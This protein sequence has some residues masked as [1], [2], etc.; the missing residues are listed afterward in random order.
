MN[1]WQESTAWGYKEMLSEPWGLQMQ[2]SMQKKAGQLVLGGPYLRNVYSPVF[3]L[4]CELLG[5]MLRIGSAQGSVLRP[6]LMNSTASKGSSTI[7]PL[8][9]LL[10]VYLPHFSYWCGF[11]RSSRASPTLVLLKEIGH[12]IWVKKRCS[13]MAYF[14]S[15][16]AQLCPTAT[17]WQ[18]E[19]RLDFSLQMAPKQ[20]TLVGH[21]V[22][23]HICCPL[24]DP[25]HTSVF[26]S[27]LTPEN[28]S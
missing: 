7:F 3:I 18:T 20:N 5:T 25:D 13:F 14:S 1:L 6:G 4:K 24:Q 10:C 28:P 23:D 27:A 16:L 22:S 17:A 2:I 12:F 26:H 8:W 21:C 19:H 15:G 9:H 11:Q